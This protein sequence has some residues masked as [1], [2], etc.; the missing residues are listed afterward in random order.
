MNTQFRNKLREALCLHLSTSEPTSE[1]AIQ[2]AVRSRKIPNPRSLGWGPAMCLGRGNE[3]FLVYVPSSPEIPEWVLDSVK[4][5][6]KFTNVKVLAA[7]LPTRECTTVEIAS[8]VTESCAKHGFGLLCVDGE[9]VYTVLPPRRLRLRKCAGNGT[10]RGHIPSWLI[11]R[12]LSAVSFSDALTKELT[13]FADRYKRLTRRAKV[14]YEE[15]ATVLEDF[16]RRVRSK[17]APLVLPLE[18]FL[19]LK[20]WEK[21][22]ANLGARDHYFHT[23]NNLLLGLLVGTELLKHRLPDA[24]PES[25]VSD[26]EGRYGKL[27]TWE[28]LWFITCLNHDPGYVGE[29]VWPAILAQYALRDSSYLKRSMPPEIADALDNGWKTELKQ[30]RADLLDLYRRIR[31]VWLPPQVAGKIDDEF[32]LALRKAYFDGTR[33]SHS[34]LS[35]LTLIRN[36]LEDPT[37]TP[38][39]EEYNRSLAALEIAALAIVF[40]DPR[41]RALLENNGV[42]AVPFEQL[43]YAALLVFVDAL[44]EDRRRINIESWP[45]HGV[46]NGVSILRTG[47]TVRADVCLRELSLRYWPAKLIEYSDALRWLNASTTVSFEIDCKPDS[48]I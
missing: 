20:A 30:S 41:C 46:L 42:P 5:L 31:N 22:G 2:D 44:Q 17:A 40:H 6:R 8:G 14:S 33:S 11:T 48:R 45:T 16:L 13:R 9:D 3:F 4:T 37:N 35:G 38:G 25:F 39:T 27:L 36:Y 19:S 29:K 23:F 28:A 10:E 21:Q 15:E 34:L 47:S 24:A 12:V 32:D 1:L 18:G 26:E 43:P 7:A